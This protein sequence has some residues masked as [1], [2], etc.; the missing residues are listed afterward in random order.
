[1]TSSCSPPRRGRERKR[2][3]EGEEIRG[4]D[5]ENG[6]KESPLFLHFS[7]RGEFPFFLHPDRGK[8]KKEMSNHDLQKRKGKAYLPT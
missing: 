4:V 2:E 5:H 6:R 8:G 3:E 7:T 1:M